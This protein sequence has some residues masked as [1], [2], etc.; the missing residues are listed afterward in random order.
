MNT[1][2][3]YII[4]VTCVLLVMAAFTITFF[5]VRKKNTRINMTVSSMTGDEQNYWNPDIHSVS[6]AENGYYYLHYDGN[7]LFVKYFDEATKRSVPVC[8]KAECSHN[9]KTCNAWLDTDE[10]LSSPIYYYNKNIYVVRV[11]GGMAKLVSIKADGSDRKDIAQLFANDRVTS[12]S[13][14]FHNGYVYA[15]DH[16]GHIGSSDSG[17]EIIK[18]INIADGSSE[19]IVEYEGQNSAV[20]GA[21]SYGDKLFYK[22][23]KY[24]VDRQTLK[25]DMDFQLYYYDYNKKETQKVSDMNICDFFVD[26]D[27]GILYYFVTGKGLY[28]QALDGKNNKLIYKADEN[29]VSAV[30]SFDGRYIYMSN[31]GIG[32]ATDLSKTVEREVCVIDAAGNQ[33]DK[34]KLGNEIEDLYFGDEKYLFGTKNNKLVYIDKQSIGS[35]A[36]DWQDAE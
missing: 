31:G 23:F 17:K 18:K 28:S 29:M 33:I 1:K 13:M 19:N 22:I 27:N 7:N 5:A 8:A 26:T 10:Y 14:V 6:R 25:A 32:S 12:I 11:D 36:G 34:I 30:I 9:S 35:G 24:S 20:M 3:K 15:Y 4:I 21:R 2:R 16:I